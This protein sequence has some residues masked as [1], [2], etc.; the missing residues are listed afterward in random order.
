[1][2]GVL[3]PKIF[4]G[5]VP[6]YILVLVLRFLWVYPISDLRNSCYRSNYQTGFRVLQGCQIF[7]RTTYQKRGKYTKLQQTITNGH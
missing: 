2:E 1:L 5:P 7:L 4:A 6:A 3:S